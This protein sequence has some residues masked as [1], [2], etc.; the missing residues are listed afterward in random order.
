MQNSVFELDIDPAQETILRCGLERIID[1]EKDSVRFY[2]LGKS[3]KNKVD[4]IGRK[5]LITFGDDL[6]L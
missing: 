5:Q 1:P 2:R 4:S 6:I 3:W